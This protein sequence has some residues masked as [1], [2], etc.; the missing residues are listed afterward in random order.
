MQDHARRFVLQQR[1]WC[2]LNNVLENTAD[3]GEQ[4]AL[5]FVQGQFR[6]AGTKPGFGAMAADEQGVHGR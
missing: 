1:S 4:L 5:A 3:F 2:L 6:G